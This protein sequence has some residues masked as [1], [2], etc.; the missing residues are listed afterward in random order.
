M[1]AKEEELG[2]V[3]KRMKNGSVRRTI[4]DALYNCE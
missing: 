4:N 1:E 2:R 3:G